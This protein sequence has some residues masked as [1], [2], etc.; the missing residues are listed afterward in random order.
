M[1]NKRQRWPALPA[2]GVAVIADASRSYT[3]EVLS[4]ETN[5]KD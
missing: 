2:S 3:S 5:G 1:Q 4:T